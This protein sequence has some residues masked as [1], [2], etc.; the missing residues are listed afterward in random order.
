MQN[1][2]ELQKKLFEKY[3]Y[4]LSTD[5][6]AWFIYQIHTDLSKDLVEM[7]KK[8]EKQKE[9]LDI[10]NIKDILDFFTKKHTKILVNYLNEF[11]KTKEV[12]DRHLH[13]FN[14]I[15][16]NIRNEGKAINI[17]METTIFDI[18][19]QIE[20]D[21]YK[22]LEKVGSKGQELVKEIKEQINVYDMREYRQAMVESK[23]LMLDM[24]SKRKTDALLFGLLGA[25]SFF[26]TVDVFGLH[27]IFY[28]FIDS[29]L[30]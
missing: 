12:I 29:L 27:T 2:E 4:V 14:R 22:V 11:K 24:Q 25:S 5:D 7:M 16:L 6:P 28:E 15:E 18:I 10:E 20:S 19:N 9:D 26:L 30:H 13:E 17:L 23:E 1:N 8:I 3:G 21:S